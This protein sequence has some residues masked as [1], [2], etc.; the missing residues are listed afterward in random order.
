MVKKPSKSL[1]MNAV[2]VES[3]LKK[4]LGAG[5]CHSDC[6]ECSDEDCEDAPYDLL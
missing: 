1:E 2:K 6:E 5:H 4:F 3:K